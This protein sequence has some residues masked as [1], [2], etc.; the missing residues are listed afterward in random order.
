MG[1]LAMSNVKVHPRILQRIQE[2]R[3]AREDQLLDAQVRVYSRLCKAT[4][5][6]K[7]TGDRARLWKR[8]QTHFLSM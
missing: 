4:K 2:I 6:L 5:R 1:L 7:E 8:S 3:S